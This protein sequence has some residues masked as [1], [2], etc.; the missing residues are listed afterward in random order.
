M[1]NSEAIGSTIILPSGDPTGRLFRG[2]G[3]ERSCFGSTLRARPRLRRGR[4]PSSPHRPRSGPG[5]V[6]GD[7]PLGVGARLVV[8]ALVVRRLHQVGG[9][10]V[11]L[12]ADAVV[13]RQLATAHRV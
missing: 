11:E 9:G 8:G 13:E 1:E 6:L 12:T 4:G 7:E 5:R 10:P 2:G 3:P